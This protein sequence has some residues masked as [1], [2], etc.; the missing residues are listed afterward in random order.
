MRLIR[1]SRVGCAYPTDK[2]G[3]VCGCEFAARRDYGL[4]VI[5]LCDDH[6]DQM[7][8]E[9]L[10]QDEDAIEGVE[11]CDT[12]ASMDALGEMFDMAAVN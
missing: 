5:E 12:P 1:L 4:M 9:L 11:W 3:G 8:T 10:I 7:S 6:H 2:H